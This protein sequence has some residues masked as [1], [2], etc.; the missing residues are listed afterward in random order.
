MIVAV[1]VEITIRNVPRHFPGTP[2][3]RGRRW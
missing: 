3:N 2:L 1:Q